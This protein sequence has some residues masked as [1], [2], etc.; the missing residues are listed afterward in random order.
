MRT[1]IS[2]RNFI[3]W[4]FGSKNEKVFLA[5]FLKLPTETFIDI[6]HSRV[7]TKNH[8]LCFYLIVNIMQLIARKVFINLSA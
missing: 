2:R 7:A 3:I 5:F 1:G 8:K 6:K 4:Y